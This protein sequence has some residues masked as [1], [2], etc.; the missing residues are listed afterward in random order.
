MIIVNKNEGEKIPY[1][2][3]GSKI[4]FDDDLTINLAKREEDDAV[5]ID[6]CYDADGALVVGAAAGR[7]YVAEIDI[8]AR[9]YVETEEETEERQ[10]LREMYL[11]AFRE[12][13]K[14]QLDNIRFVED[15]TEDMKDVE[16]SVEEA[17]E[18]LKEA[19]E[20]IAEAEARIE[21]KL[22]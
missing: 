12:N 9:E 16:E 8:P 5:H 21:A 13:L 19:I 3:S 14:A 7:R 6:I 4:C 22:N 18:E 20:D 2:Q 10:R 11:A 1:E 17:E 15:M